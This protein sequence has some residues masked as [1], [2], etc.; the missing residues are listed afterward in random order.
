[1]TFDYFHGDQ[2]DQFSFIRIPRKL[3]TDKIFSDLSPLAK[4][5]YAILLD[6]ISLSSKNGWIDEQNRVYIIYQISDIMEDLGLGKKKAMDLLSELEIFGLVEKQRRGRGLPNIL[7]VKSFLAVSE[8]RSAESESSIRKNTMFAR[9]TKIDTPKSVNDGSKTP[10]KPAA[11]R[12]VEISTS[13]NTEVNVAGINNF[14]VLGNNEDII[15]RQDEAILPRRATVDTSIIDDAAETGAA[16]DSES[17]VHRFTISAADDDSRSIGSDVWKSVEF[18][19]SKSVEI[20][21]SRSTEME[22]SRSTQ[23]DTSRSAEMDTSRSAQTGLLEVPKSTPLINKTNMSKTEKSYTESNHI[24]P[25][26]SSDSDEIRQDSDAMRNPTPMEYRELI[27][28]NIGYHDLL[29]THPEEIG[30]I[31]GI[32]DL[33]LESLLCTDETMVIASRTYPSSIV[34]SKFMKLNYCNIEYVLFSLSR[35]TTKVKNIK[36]YLLATLFNAP[37]TMDSYYHAEVRHDMAHQPPQIKVG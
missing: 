19:T 23:I 26:L 11:L 13:G 21:L 17:Y 31:D 4:M 34:K 6:R 35:N 28:D 25:I 22:P 1:M 32:V 37:S 24:H 8:D 27:E 36:K 5:L 29:I 20:E 9:D 12:S 18:D 10:D 2:A 7:Y 3:M 16:V 15:P 33:I 30:V 14:A